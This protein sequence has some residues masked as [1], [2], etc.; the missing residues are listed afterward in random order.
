MHHEEEDFPE[1]FEFKPER[2][3][4]D[5]DDAKVINSETLLH[6][7]ATFGF[8]SSFRKTSTTTNWRI[9][10]KDLSWSKTWRDLL[11]DRSRSLDMGFRHFTNDERR[12]KSH[13]SDWSYEV[14]FRHYIVSFSHFMPWLLVLTRHVKGTRRISF[15]DEN[16]VKCACRDDS[17]SLGR[18]CLTWRS[19]LDYKCC[20]YKS[21]W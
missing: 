14:Y 9:G 6:G 10:K 2:W 21:N 8:V 19:C 12:R 18:G 15:E 3:E 13:H 20:V 7:H 4:A 5:L 17:E 1:P 11:M 16:Q